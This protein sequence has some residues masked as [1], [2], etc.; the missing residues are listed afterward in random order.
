MSSSGAEPNWTQPLMT[1]QVKLLVTQA[2]RR[3]SPMIWPSR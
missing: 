2:P 3:E 1:E